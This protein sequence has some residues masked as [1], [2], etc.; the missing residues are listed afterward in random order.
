MGE[1]C[2]DCD[3]ALK[4]LLPDDAE[5]ESSHEEEQATS[6]TKEIPKGKGWEI[7]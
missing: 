4:L 6:K 7:N 3:A 1:Y 2:L 5:E